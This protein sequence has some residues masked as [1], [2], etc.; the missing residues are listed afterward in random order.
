MDFPAI[1]LTAGKGTRMFPFSQKYSKPLFPILNKPLIVYSIE[2]LIAA[3]FLEII[4]V[5]NKNEKI[6]QSIL[7][8]YF[9]TLDIKYVIQS[10]ALG[11]GHAVLQT[12]NYFTADNFLVQAGDSLFFQST[13]RKM[14]EKHVSE[15]NTLTLSLEEMSFKLMRHSST[16]DYR[17]GQVWKIKEKPET[18][19]EILSKYNS[20]ALYIFSRSIF[21]TLQ[22]IN[23]SKRNEYELATAINAIINK[24]K[25][26]GGVLTERVFH[27]STPYDCWYLNMKF[28]QEQGEKMNWIGKNVNI[29]V[30]C[31][32]ESSVIGDNCKVQSGVNLRKCVVLPDTI[33]KESYTNALLQFEHHQS[34]LENTAFL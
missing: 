10:E 30:T 9:P 14:R 2:Q 22:N 11:T 25:R 32:I 21:N 15:K 6:I 27:L 19:A 8:Q 1:I 29:A 13:L 18:E 26:V 3:G 5:I 34:F 24:G 16:V 17:E 7:S 12:R 20:S 33:V 4:I 23:R 31:K 28:L